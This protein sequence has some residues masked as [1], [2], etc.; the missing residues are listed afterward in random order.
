M[1]TIQV[2]ANISIIA[3]AIVGIISLILKII[4]ELSIA[5]PQPFRTRLEYLDNFGDSVANFGSGPL[6][7][8]EIKY[9]YNGV[10]FVGDLVDLYTE[11]LNLEK[12]LLWKTFS[13]KED[14]INRALKPGEDLELVEIDP[15]DDWNGD[16][17]NLLNA[18]MNI[19]S[20]ITMEITYK[21]IYGM[22]KTVSL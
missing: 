20:Q 12:D 8:Q 3:T 19:R 9:F 1:E 6:K 4:Q 18:L 17:E 22:K 11:K 7:I 2:I 16:I 15:S 21:N 14:I 13:R 5:K 10:L